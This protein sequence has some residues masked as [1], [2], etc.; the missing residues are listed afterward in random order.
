M[1]QW[2]TSLAR[3]PVE[4]PRDEV[5]FLIGPHLRASW[6]CSTIESSSLE[7]GRTGACGDETN[8]WRWSRSLDASLVEWLTATLRLRSIFPQS[9]LFLMLQTRAKMLSLGF[10]S[11]RKEFRRDANCDPRRR[12]DPCTP[13]QRYISDNF[14]RSKA[15]CTT[16][17][18]K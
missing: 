16:K 14:H 13:G 11:F 15:G 18:T 6:K 10:W 17:N 9:L 7:R 4:T 12:R 5:S 2:G 3:F 1:Q 8:I